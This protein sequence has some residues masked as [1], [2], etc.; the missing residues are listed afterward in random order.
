MEIIA[1]SIS[2]VVV[3]IAL[4]RQLNLERQERSDII[5]RHQQLALTVRYAQLA[6]EHPEF[7]PEDIEGLRRA[8]SSTY[9]VEGA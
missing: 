6:S 1:V 7:S 2:F 9:E 4:L 3:V 8:M 5:D